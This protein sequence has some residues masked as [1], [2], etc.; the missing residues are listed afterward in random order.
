MRALCPL[1]QVFG[2][3]AK[4]RQCAVDPGSGRVHDECGLR[5]RDGGGR[6]GVERPCRIDGEQPQPRAVQDGPMIGPQPESRAVLR[7]DP[8]RIFDERQREPFRKRDL[9]VGVR[10]DPWKPPGVDHR[11]VVGPRGLRAVR[12]PARIAGV[13]V[14]ERQ[15]DLDEPRA[16]GLRDARLLLQ[17]EEPQGRTLQPAEAVVH[18]DVQPQRPDELRGQLEQP[19]ALFQ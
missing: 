12:R 2:L 10:T 7:R 9:R 8:P 18:R 15:P 5:S 1:Q 11:L 17:P 19:R 3:H 6:R 13:A 4:L 14:I 16:A